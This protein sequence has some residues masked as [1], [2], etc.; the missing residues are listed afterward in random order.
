MQLCEQV[1][2][3]REG[4]RPGTISPPASALQAAAG[5]LL[6][7]T[8]LSIKIFYSM[9][10]PLLAAYICGGILKFTAPVS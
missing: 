6:R 2:Q 10:F 8:I 3:D 4:K 7:V 1:C 9:N 5:G